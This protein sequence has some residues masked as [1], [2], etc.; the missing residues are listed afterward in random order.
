MFWVS[1]RVPTGIVWVRF[2]NAIISRFGGSPNMAINIA[3][4]NLKAI[5]AD[6]ILNKCLY[7]LLF[8]AGLFKYFDYANMSTPRKRE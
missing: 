8:M 1:A 3:T 2:S 7:E 5:G 6:F 4:N